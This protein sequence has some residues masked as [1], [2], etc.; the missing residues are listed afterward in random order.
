MTSQPA[1]TR[2]ALVDDHPSVIEGLKSVISLQPDLVVAG[3]S[4]TAAGVERVFRLNRPDVAILDISLPDAKGLCWIAKVMSEFPKV[5]IILHSHH[6]E[7]DLLRSA[8]QMQVAGYVLKTSSPHSV[9][10]A[11]RSIRAGGTFIDPVLMSQALARG[12]VPPSRM[13]GMHVAAQAISPRELE[14]LRLTALGY[15]IKEIADEIKVSAKSVETY[16]LRGAEKLGLKTRSAIVRYAIAC[17]WLS[18]I[19]IL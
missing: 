7:Q 13:S 12:P 16:K 8:L 17:G 11:I 9:I 6:S 2:I 3:I 19:D 1:P 18:G 14:T 15:G 5:K 10:Y 4:D